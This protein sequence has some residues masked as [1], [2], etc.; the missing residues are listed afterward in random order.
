MDVYVHDRQSG[1]TELLSVDTAG[2]QSNGPSG[3]PSISADGRYVAFQSSATNIVPGDTNGFD[4]VFVRDRQSG[5]TER[6][7]LDSGGTQVSGGSYNPSISASGRHVAFYSDA[8]ALVPGDTNGHSDVFIKDR[9]SGITERISVD[10]FG[11]QGS[12][13]SGPY[14]VSISADGNFVAFASVATN[15]VQGDTNGSPDIFVR[16]RQGGTTERV[17]V[18][19]GGAQG[20]GDSIFPSISAS[21][22][23]V[24]FES[25]ASNL[26]PGDTN[27]V[28]DVL[29]RDRQTG[30]T[31]L[32]SASS[33][34]VEE[35]SVGGSPSISADGHE[36]AFQ[37]FADNL[38]PN[39]TNSAT[40]VFVHSDAP[41]TAVAFCFGDGTSTACPCGNASPPGAGAGC[42]SSLGIGGMLL[43]SGIA[44]IVGDSVVLQG[45]QMPDSSALYFQGTTLQS[46]GPGAVFGDGLRCAG[47]QVVRLG[48]KVNVANASAYPGPGDP[49]L[50][51]RGN[52]HAGDFRT[53]QVWYRN[54]APFCTASTFN[55]TNGLELTWSP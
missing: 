32:A 28:G 10:S 46:G 44:N 20:N 24:A 29:V 51:V 1:T 26:V 43:A 39:D 54:A 45:L 21:G 30:T 37:S 15:L 55:L 5:I 47:G 25:H 49:A 13:D 48:I 53:Y 2:T 40:D 52:C 35:N 4:D 17:S 31:A 23:Y 50:S 41:T 7:S 36:I 16:D 12:L 8:S 27:G 34:G 42:L 19:S 9:Q 3:S 33:S 11:V 38:V 22:R 18:D 14:G 6:I